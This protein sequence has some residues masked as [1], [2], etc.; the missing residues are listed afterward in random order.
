M[1]KTEGENREGGLNSSS[2]DTPLACILEHQPEVH[3]LVP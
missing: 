3:V 1:V 2:V